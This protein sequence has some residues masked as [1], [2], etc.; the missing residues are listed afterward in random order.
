M[1]SIPPPPP[2]A[3]D[4]E[5]RPP[6]LGNDELQSSSRRIFLLPRSNSSLPPPPP[7]ADRECSDKLHQSFRP[8]ILLLTCASFRVKASSSDPSSPS[9]DLFLSC[10]A[11][12]ALRI[13]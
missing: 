7:A 12:A 9:P 6:P 4:R 1:R 11:K 2:P 13:W 8:H 5:Q 3:S 10:M